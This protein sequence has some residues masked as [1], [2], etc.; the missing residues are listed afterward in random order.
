MKIKKLPLK[1]Q[2]IQ[3]LQPLVCQPWFPHLAGGSSQSA[4]G[5][6]W[7]FW[8]QECVEGT[9]VSSAGTAGTPAG[10]QLWIW[11]SVLELNSMGD[12]LPFLADRWL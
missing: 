4:L 11:A 6:L 3:A 12:S 10:V 7:V 8:D 2:S 5:I 9:K 1:L